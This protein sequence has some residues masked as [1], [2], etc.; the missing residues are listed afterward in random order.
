MTIIKKALSE[1]S[2]LVG[3]RFIGQ[4]LSWAATIIVA[5]LLVPDDY[6]LMEIATILTGYV[7]L[8]S[9]LGLGAA[10]VQK[11]KMDENEL[12]SLFWLMV[13]WS[14]ILALLCLLLAYPTV[15]IFNDERTYYITQSCALIYPLSSIII[16]PRNILNRE[17][18]FKDI[19][20][21]E[22]SSTIITCLSMVVLAYMGAGVWTLVAGSILKALFRAIM[23]F[24]YV[25]WKPT[26]HFKPKE[27]LPYLRFGINLAIAN[28]LEY[29]SNKS[30]RFFGGRSIG[31]ALLGQY[32]LALQLASIPN[33]KIVSLINNISFPVFS[34]FQTQKEDAKLFFLFLIEG[35]SFLTGPLFFGIAIVAETLI[36]VL[37]GEKWIGAILPLQ[38]LSIGQYFV[39]LSTVA[40]VT[41]MAQGRTSWNLYFN[42]INFIIIPISFFIAAKYGLEKLA[43]PWITVV[44]IIRI[45]FLFKTAKKLNLEVTSI[46][47]SLIHPSL[48]ISFMLISVIIF[49]SKFYDVN[50]SKILFLLEEI[51]VG[52]LSYILYMFIIRKGLQQKIKKALEIKVNSNI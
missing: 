39:A 15:L 22:A 46:I 34:R 7:A 20:I 14:F 37:V 41:N 49:K 51:A 50:I 12:S 35:I 40:S 18:R 42:I 8:F 9:E 32:A 48:A 1:A 23:I 26:F 44:P 27:T 13:I 47:K 3:F 6:G 19:G 43:I 31:S 16:V 2:W 36:I 25:S 11:D 38:L 52:A 30:D 21:I 24:Y 5:R 17:M 29:A 4:I 28:S 45:L 33:E 10:I